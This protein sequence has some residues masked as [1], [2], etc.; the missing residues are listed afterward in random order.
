M[1]NSFQRVYRDI[2]TSLSL[3]VGLILGSG[4]AAPKNVAQF[5]SVQK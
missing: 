3:H 4:P 5:K 1:D 2:W